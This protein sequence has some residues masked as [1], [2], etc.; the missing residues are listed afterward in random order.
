MLFCG[1]AAAVV[2]T[3][4]HGLGARAYRRVR[5]TYYNYTRGDHIFVYL[6]VLE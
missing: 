2:L 5:K 1:V 3:D 4:F 6:Y